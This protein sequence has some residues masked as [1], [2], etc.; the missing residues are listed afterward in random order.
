MY[1]ERPQLSTINKGPITHIETNLLSVRQAEEAGFDN[2]NPGM[3]GMQIALQGYNIDGKVV[4]IVPVVLSN[5]EE[6]EAK[7]SNTGF[8]KICK[9]AQEL[10]K[11][12]LQVE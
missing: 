12:N 9:K 11:N 6:D 10:Y 7:G 1:S 3:D 8:K 2:Y 5:E 4:K